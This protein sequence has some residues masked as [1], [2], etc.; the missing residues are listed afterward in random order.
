[1]NLNSGPQM[2]AALSA[3]IGVDLPNMDA[4]KTLK[5]LAG[6]HEVIAKLLEYR[7]ITKL[8]GTY[9]ETLPLKQ[10]PTTGRWHSRFNPM[11]TVTGRFSAGK[12]EDNGSW[13]QFNVQNQ[14]DEARRMFV[15]PPGK[16][17]VSADFK[18]QEI[19]C[20]AYLS[21]EPA[22]VE[23]FEKNL[24]PYAMLAV[25]FTGKPYEQVNKNPDG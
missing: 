10:N 1:L 8:S 12:A 23:A 19:R 11:G 6:Q 20:V 2:K 5:P 13:Q 16:V 4:K 22:L 21:G 9:I 18:A 17:L 25:R 24:D 15:A 7:K 3:A 14:P